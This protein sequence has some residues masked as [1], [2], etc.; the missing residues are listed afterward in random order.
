MMK[1]ENAKNAK[2]CTL[3]CVKAGGKYVLFDSAGNATY[4]LDDQDKP[5][6]YAGQKVTVTGTYD[7]S[8]KTI[9][10]EKIEPRS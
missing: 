9:H 8:S 7:G 3:K 5:A 6:E 1:S 2:D 10:V 4:Q